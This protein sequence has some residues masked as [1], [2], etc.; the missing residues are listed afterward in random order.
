MPSIECAREP[1][2]LPGIDR[3]GWPGTL[4]TPGPDVLPTPNPGTGWPGG[5]P[6]PVPV[7]PPVPVPPTPTE[8]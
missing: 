4:P 3:R 8:R 2:P 7:D 1:S 6:A 5:Q